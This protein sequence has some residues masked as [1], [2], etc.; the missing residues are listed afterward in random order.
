MFVA[1]SCPTVCDPMDCSP[2]GSSVHGILQAR[3]LHFDEVV[4]SDF[5]SDVEHCSPGV[6]ARKLTLRMGMGSVG[7]RG[8]GVL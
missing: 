4:V 7:I 1:Q 8:C 6:R 5:S 3:I 2:L